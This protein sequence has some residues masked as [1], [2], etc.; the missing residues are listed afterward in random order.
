MMNQRNPY[1]GGLSFAIPGGSVAWIAVDGF[2][3]RLF[4][5]AAIPGRHGPVQDHIPVLFPKLEV[6]RHENILCPFDFR[7]TRILSGK[8]RIETRHA[9]LFERTTVPFED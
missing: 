1:R 8:C 6:L 4:R 5:S 2:P 9:H 7:I 3:D